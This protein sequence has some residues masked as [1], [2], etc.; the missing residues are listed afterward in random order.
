MRHT[1]T[2]LHF[3]L[4]HSSQGSV[5]PDQLYKIEVFRGDFLDARSAGIRNGL[6][7]V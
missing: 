2:V 5:N 7:A 1:L 3:D 4:K 6:L